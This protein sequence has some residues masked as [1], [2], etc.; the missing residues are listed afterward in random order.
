[1]PSVAGLLDGIDLSALDRSQLVSI[2]NGLKASQDEARRKAYRTDPLRWAV[3]KLGIVYESMVWSAAD[4]FP[5]DHGWDSCRYD[6]NDDGR[7]TKEVP[8]PNAV[9]YAMRSIAAGVRQIG[10]EGGTGTS[11]TFGLAICVLWFLDQYG[12]APGEE[13]NC[14]VVTFSTK[15]DQLKK[16]LWKDI[17]RLWPRFKKLYP[18][19]ELHPGGL[20]I[21]MQPR[22]ESKEAWS[23]SGY[24]ARVGASETAAAAVKGMHAPNL[25]F[26]FEEMQGIDMAIP[27]AIRTTCTAPNN[28]MVAL[29]N[30]QADFD[31]LHKFCMKRGVLYLRVSALDHPNVVLNNPYFVEGAASKILIDEVLVE[32]DGDEG[33]PYFLSNI[34]GV[35]PTSS[36]LSIFSQNI[37]RKTKKFLFDD[38]ELDILIHG[39][40]DVPLTAN[41]KGTTILIEP[42]ETTHINRYYLCCDIAGDD[43]TGDAHACI[44][45]DRISKAPVALIHMR[46]PRDEFA[47]EVLRIAEL[48]TIPWT[49]RS[50]KYEPLLAWERNMGA[51]NLEEG[52]KKYPN[53]YRAT[54][55]DT[56]SDKR[57]KV[58]GWH[59]GEKSRYEMQEALKKW[60]VR[61]NTEP[62]L[63]RI[64]L[65][66]DEL[67][68]FIATA[69]LRGGKTRYE[70]APGAF[71]D[72]AIAWML[73][74]VIDQEARDRP[75]IRIRGEEAGEEPIPP[76]MYESEEEVNEGEMWRGGIKPWSGQIS[77]WG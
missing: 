10:I 3:D 55:L 75:P 41:S 14:Q 61:L 27:A 51:F 23:A 71:D 18:D 63:V 13:P 25:L 45:G 33:H 1:M 64:Y 53:C 44:V 32:V 11:K 2:H 12:P 48:Y 21:Y 39:S 22:S 7:K 15:E 20:H 56:K 38:D 69:V 73:F 5:Q 42:V 74:L 65:L 29:G 47:H 28:I 43:I 24:S 54:S 57:R 72:I 67:R 35:C 46:G 16:H 36:A 19:A 37:S 66:W 50:V 52:I 40:E 59:T 76:S 4:G 60:I 17:G 70:A 26:I 9:H 30:P 6:Y 8:L 49:M 58:M 68:T 31:N 62:T 77:R 34:R